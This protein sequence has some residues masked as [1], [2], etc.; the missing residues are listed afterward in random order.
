MV[1]EA[2][3]R[4]VG[5]RVGVAVKA[6]VRTGVVLAYV[7]RRDA[8]AE[9]ALSGIPV[10]SR[11]HSISA[12]IKGNRTF[13]K[14]RL[15]EKVGHRLEYVHSKILNQ[16]CILPGNADY[17]F[18]VNATVMSNTIFVKINLLSACGQSE[19]PAVPVIQL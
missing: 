5:R 6:A 12:T 10:L 4:G 2:A 18:I 3:A 7:F 11:A 16:F 17:Q 19:I 8:A 14:C 13:R 1:E 15:S 9:F